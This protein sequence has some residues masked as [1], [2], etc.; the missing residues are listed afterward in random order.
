[1]KKLYAKGLLFLLLVSA[2][3]AGLLLLSAREPYRQII[4]G[5]THSRD[6]MDENE[7][8]PYF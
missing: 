2:L 4:A 3:C 7:M 5:W 8:L 1:M 6:F